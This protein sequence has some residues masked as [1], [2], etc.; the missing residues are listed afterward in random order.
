MKYILILQLLINIIYFLLI[1]LLLKKDEVH[2]HV[3]IDK[4]VVKTSIEKVNNEILYGTLKKNEQPIG[5]AGIG[6]LVP[7]A[8]MKECLEFKE[9]K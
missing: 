2:L 1:L 3:N 4:E 7:D 9:E 5:I 8:A 6:K